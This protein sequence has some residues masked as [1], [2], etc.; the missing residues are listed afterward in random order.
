MPQEGPGPGLIPVGWREVQRE[1]PAV[2][3]LGNFDGVHLGHARILDALV[4]EAEDTGWDPVLVTFEPHPR[5]FFRP[6]EPQSLLATPSEKLALL[7]QWPV[8]VIPLR[9]DADLAGLEAEAFIREFLQERVQGRR[10]L[11]GHDHRFGKGA[12]GDADLLRELTGTEDEDSV[13]LLDPL[14]KDGVVVSSSSIRSCLEAGK[15]DKAALLLGRAFS[16]AGQVTPGDGRGRGLG[17]PT[18]NLDIR[19]AHKALVARGV[20]GGMATLANGKTLPGVANIGVNPTFDGTAMK[21]EVHL[22]DFKGDLYGQW[23]EFSLLF[24]I[25]EERK[26][27]SVEALTD[28]IRADVETVRIRLTQ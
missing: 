23:L 5:H 24:Q 6:K 13:I 27:A 9:F 4:A 14:I 19:S 15:V 26:F 2:V 3:A 7:G 17:F 25:R 28:Q 21:I 10:F 1:S 11:L 20:Y 8:E 22:L 12:R 16:Y 18:A